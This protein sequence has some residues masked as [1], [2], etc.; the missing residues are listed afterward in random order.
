MSYRLDSLGKSFFHRFEP[1][2]DLTDI[3]EATVY[4]QKVVDI[5][6]ESHVDMPGWLNNLG[7]AFLCRF[8]GTEVLSDITSAISYHRKAAHLT[9][10]GYASVPVKTCLAS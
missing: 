7:N 1:T 8:E 4:W 6:P 10:V 2:G 5:T 3:S 9:P